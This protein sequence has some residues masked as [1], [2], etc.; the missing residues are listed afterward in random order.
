M[1]KVIRHKSPDSIWLFDFPS[2]EAMDDCPELQVWLSERDIQIILQGLKDVH[3]YQSR[4]FVESEGQSY[5][6]VDATQFET[7]Q[8]WVSDMF[9]NIGGYQMCNEIMQGIL[10]ALQAIADRECCPT[11]GAGSGVFNSGSRGSG[12]SA[13]PAS[14]YEE[15]GEIPPSGFSTWEEYRQHKCNAAND[16]VLALKV[17]LLSFSNLIPGE[18][19]FTAI[20]SGLV[21]VMLTPIPYD[22]LAYIVGL[23]TVGA[24]EYS[25]LAE[26]SAE[27]E[28][29]ANSLV[30]ILYGASDATVAQEDFRTEVN[31]IIDGMDII[32]LGKDWLKDIIVGMT[33][34]D[35]FNRL[36]SNV[37]TTTQDSD[38][39][40]CGADCSAFI[41]DDINGSQTAGTLIS[42]SLDSPGEVVV[43]SSTIDWGGNAEN[44]AMMIAIQG[45]ECCMMVIE[46]TSGTGG[47]Q[48]WTEANA[49]GCG[50]DVGFAQAGLPD[51]GECFNRIYITRADLGNTPFQV[52]L[53]W[54]SP[55]A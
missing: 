23:L 35:V 11:G 17:D 22:D 7:F 48:F 29:N 4:V 50:D 25:F 52:T 19:T 12:I 32:E 45:A 37:S 38:C 30:C 34:F 39:S 51:P 14:T 27:I 42:G 47:L 31:S 44:P 13:Q 9:N 10:E 46:A 5:T 28:D 26:L 41:V 21:A 16:I 36:F 2:L 18:G 1:G 43:E 6:T 24:I 40:A 49:A 20:L 55:C 15:S 3:R 33:P 53:T 8:G 54:D